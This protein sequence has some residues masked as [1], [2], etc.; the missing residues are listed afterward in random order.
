[1]TV[2]ML[3]GIARF[4][5]GQISERV[6]SGQEGPKDRRRLTKKFGV[7]PREIISLQGAADSS[8]CGLLSHMR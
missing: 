7:H 1:M 3:A 5:R 2:A 6:K 8:N 4:E